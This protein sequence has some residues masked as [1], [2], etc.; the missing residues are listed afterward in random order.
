[1]NE[2]LAFYLPDDWYEVEYEDVIC[3]FAGADDENHRAAVIIDTL[4]ADGMT[5]EELEEESNN[6]IACCTISTNGIRFFPCR[7]IQR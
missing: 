7:P 1:M 2:T 6:Q 3:S 5:I 4:Q